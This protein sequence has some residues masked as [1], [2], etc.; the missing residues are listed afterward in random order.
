VEQISKIQRGIEYPATDEE[1]KAI[2]RMKKRDREQ[3]QD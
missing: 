2:G 3:D 1:G